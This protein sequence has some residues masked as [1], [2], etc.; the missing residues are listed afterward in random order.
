MLLPFAKAECIECGVDEVGRGCL[1]GPVVAAA[2]IWDPSVDH[3]CVNDI[4]DSKK[5]SAQKRR[6]LAEFIKEHAKGW[7]VSFVDNRVIDDINILQ[8]TYKA[9]HECVDSLVEAN[10]SI[11][12]ILVDGNRFKP[13]KDVAH[14]CVVKG[15]NTYIS[16]AAASILAKVARDD[17]MVGAADEEGC[18]V[19]G[20]KQNMGYG[21]KA[22]MDAIRA[23]GFSELHRKTFKLKGVDGV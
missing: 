23:H 9:M 5:L 2:V 22:H 12:H 21:T 7:A 10:H 19:Y 11:D 8:A 20:W 1:A 4:K 16:I 13:Y 18:D 3:P 17:F 15:D 6:T 14:T